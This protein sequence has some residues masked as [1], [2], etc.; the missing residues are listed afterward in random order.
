MIDSNIAI[1]STWKFN[2][3]LNY[4]GHEKKVCLMVCSDDDR[5]ILSSD[6]GGKNIFWDATSGEKIWDFTLHNVITKSVTFSM[7]YS[8]V[9][10]VGSDGILSSSIC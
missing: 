8:T 7:D 1:F 5:Y 4:K 6:Q 9:L 10:L 2:E 3:I